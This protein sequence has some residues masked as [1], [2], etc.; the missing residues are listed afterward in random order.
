MRRTT[1]ARVAA[2]ALATFVWQTAA[3]GVEGQPNANRYSAGNDAA[4]TDNPFRATADSPAL[5]D[6]MLAV[7]STKA[8]SAAP[9]N[10]AAKGQS[11]QLL[12][13]ARRALSVGDLPRAQQFLAKAQELKVAYDGQGDSPQAVV[14]SIGEYQEAAA[15]RN[16]NGGANWRI[17][18]SK[19][20][21]KQADALLSWN[22][23]DTATRAANEAAQLNPQFSGNGI[24]PQDVLRRI[25]QRRKSPTS[26]AVTE[27][28]VPT[29]DAKLQTQI[30][31]G[32]AR[33]ALAAGNLPEA[34]LLAGRAS[35][36]NVPDSQFGVDEDRPSRL[37]LDIQKAA[38]TGATPAGVQ[39]PATAT[40]GAGD[41]VQAAA[42]SETGAAMKLAQVPEFTPTPLP[43]AK[44]ATPL[45]GDPAQMLEAGEQ[46][47]R[48]GDR[49]GALQSFK[50][51]YQNHAQLD[52]LAQQRLQGH[53]QML[54]GNAPNESLPVPGNLLDSAAEGQAV[55]VRQLSADVI[56]RQSEAEKLRSTDPKQA[57]KLLEESRAQV[58]ESQLSQELKSQLLRRIELTTSATNKYIEDHKA[59]LDLKATNDEILGEVHRSQA[60]KLEVQQKMAQMVDEFNKLVDEH[61]YAEAEVVANRLYEMAP[62]ELVAQQVNK[63]AKLIRRERWNQD[64]IAKAEN[65]AANMFLDVR[66][67]SAKALAHG[68]T[69][70]AF[71]TDWDT[72]KN[73]KSLDLGGGR[74]AKELEIEQKL[75]TPVLPKYTE[76]P[77]TKVVEGLSQ[78]AG[79]NIHLDPRGLSQ[80]GV[81]SDTPIT[82]NL[83]QEI[84]LKSALTLI[85]EPL[86][87]TYTIQ[88]EVLK[89]TSEQIRDGDLKIVTYP[90]GDL[91][92]PIPN[93]VPTNNI[94]LQGL[95]NDAY[96]AMGAYGPGGVGGPVSM[97]ANSRPGQ[98]RVA[99]ANGPVQANFN[100]PAN[101]PTSAPV[102]GPGGLGGAASAD[103][104]SLIDLIVSTVEHESWM[105]NGTGEGEIQ[106]FPTNLS[107]VISQTQRVHEQIADLLEQL[108]RLQDLQVTIEVRFIRL[109][110]SFF[111]RIGVDFDF[112]ITDR[113]G[114]NPASFQ[115][116]QPPP[117]I[118]ASA[119]VGLNP[120]PSET[121]N[122]NYTVDLDMPFR[123][124]SFSLATP[125]FGSPQDVGSF[126]FAILS[127]IEAFFVINASQGDQ[128]ANVL[129]APKVTLFNG[130]QANVIDSSFRPFVISVIPVVGE[131]AAAQQPV[132]VVLSEGTMMTVQAVVSDDRR[133]VR[134]TLVPF[135]SQIGD[136][137]TFTFEGSES[138][139]TSNSNTDD[140]DGEST[141]EDET[142]TT[143][144]SGTTV[145]LPTFQVITVSTTVSVPDGGTVLLGG[146][147][148]LVEGRNEFGVPLLSKVPYIDRLFRNVGIGRETDSLMMMVTPHIIIQEEEEDRLGIA[149]EQ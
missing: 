126:G 32:Q 128:R 102:G 73:R 118:G 116:G 50:A 143:S 83:P 105:E 36:L 23:F 49:E 3:H 132:I 119:S 24:T 147:K 69:P 48:A 15:M 64:I 17:A 29:A 33:T 107:L 40:P 28:P 148:R 4:A 139:S 65:G 6:G 85:L 47:L 55:L 78:L 1:T 71:P 16:L 37:A 134:L 108:R 63:Q 96:A 114:L 57:L 112:D 117:A 100:A 138:I 88:D 98:P 127:D 140:N 94:G 70:F 54:Q 9:S 93:F 74:N 84:S 125:Q 35:A 5:P 129:Q 149:S 145:Q 104:D 141:S 22:D 52:V 136:V 51:A 87:L 45:P 103:F 75:K 130:Q 89:I 21:V 80:E 43:N 12:L 72:L 20:L 97:V 11:D 2:L 41:L 60:V 77:L 110:D 27:A 30:L 8:P 38:L 92:I 135:F 53:L 122:P 61:R 101:G 95:I 91:V 44:E 79:V 18:Y 115:P 26:L 111:E 34:Q 81:R 120:A 146:I 39:L 46:A 137:Q 90:V 66:D 99:G 25:E 106:P 58:E 62:D 56:K 14:E 68:D 7:P 109:T 13:D 133:Y 10:A 144:R 76:T 82:L 86:H 19:F 124:G 113:T 121:L 142:E 31:L 59:E 131:F 42:S 123:Q 67:T